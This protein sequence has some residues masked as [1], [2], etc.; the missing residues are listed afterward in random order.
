MSIVTAARDLLSTLWGPSVEVVAA[1]RLV[2][3][4]VARLT[5]RGG[6][7]ASVIMKWVRD[8]E[9]DDPSARADPT[10]AITEGIA[11]E[12]LADHGVRRRG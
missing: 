7:V 6:P 11:L 4:S 12:F 5:V 2:P 1:E 9:A 10:Q 8:G 3:W